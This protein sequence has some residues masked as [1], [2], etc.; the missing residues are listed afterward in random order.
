[1]G[2]AMNRD[3]LEQYLA[4][5]TRRGPAPV[6]AFTGSAGGAPCGDLVRLSL[7]ATDGRIERITL[8]QE[9]CAATA[10]AAAAAAELAEG[11]SVLEAASLG[12]DEIESELGG[13]GSSHR[14][15]AALAADALHRALSSLAGSGLPIA[16][17]SPGGR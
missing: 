14:H 17:P 7:V 2:E 6:G 8:A 10:A 5:A 13:L 3:L 1:S 12:P 11:A 15:A 4:D 16:E 9:G